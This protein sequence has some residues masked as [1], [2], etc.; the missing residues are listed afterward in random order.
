[1]KSSITGYSVEYKNGEI[2]I[3]FPLNKANIDKN[4]KP[5]LKDIVSVT[6]WYTGRRGEWI[7]K[8]TV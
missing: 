1:M 5:D 6:T 8:K 2:L 3:M 4:F 7:K